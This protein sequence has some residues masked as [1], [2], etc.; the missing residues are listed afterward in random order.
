MHEHLDEA[1]LR[2]TTYVVGSYLSKRHVDDLTA[3][4]ERARAEATALT[5]EGTPVHYLRSIFIPSD[6]LCFNV[7][8]ALSSDGVREASKRA[9]NLVRARYRGGRARRRRRS[10]SV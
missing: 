9:A 5:R 7:Y 8:K 3:V 2:L 4:I 1:G 10:L 6:E